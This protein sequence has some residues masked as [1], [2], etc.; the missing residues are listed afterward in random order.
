MEQDETNEKSIKHGLFNMIDPSFQP[1]LRVKYPIIP[2]CVRS[3]NLY[4]I[5][6]P[7]PG[8]IPP[9]HTVHNSTLG[10]GR[11]D[12]FCIGL[13]II[14]YFSTWTSRILREME[15]EVDSI[16]QSKTTKY[17]IPNPPPP[18]PYQS[19]LLPTN[20]HSMSVVHLVV[21]LVVLSERESAIAPSSTASSWQDYPHCCS[22]RRSTALSTI[23]LSLGQPPFTQS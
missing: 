9:V 12:V 21:H 11:K 4:Y 13:G 22:P 8:H 15:I 19:S 1:K 2:T 18:P 7:A 5:K 3:R 23:S 10:S 16:T 20:Q 6:T 17:P 14:S